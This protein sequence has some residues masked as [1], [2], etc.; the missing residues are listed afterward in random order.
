MDALCIG[1]VSCQ[2]RAL[3]LGH[4]LRNGL[5]A[6]DRGHNKVERAR[7]LCHGCSAMRADLGYA[8]VTGASA[9][10]GRAL[11]LGLGE[12]KIGVLA[13]ARRREKL[14]ALCRELTERFGT[15]N[16]AIPADLSSRSGVLELLE[17]VRM[18]GYQVNYLVNN[19]GI[20]QQGRF[21]QLDR[22]RELATV[23]VNVEAVV[24]LC[25]HFAPA[26]VQRGAGHILNISS[27]AGYQ[28]GPYMSSY[29][30][31]KAFVTAF[32]EALHFELEGCGVAVTAV[33][34]GPIH[35]E[36][37]QSAGVED[38]NLFDSSG[39]ATPEQVA[40]VA[41]EAMLN[42]RRCVVVGLKNKILAMGG[43]LGPRSVSLRISARLNQLKD[44]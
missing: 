28:P 8:L 19:A 17:S 37:A 23:G 2:T 31:S 6:P 20:A 33:C 10:L 12:R 26:M 35:T 41:I 22:E 21:D 24:H 29:Y 42:K 7:V 5:K 40:G 30:A 44:A 9:G 25:H 16:H 4:L 36:F 1:L 3:V 15:R 43:R 27:V 13:I 18:G 11:A 38:S 34:P 39:I 32:S 14:Q